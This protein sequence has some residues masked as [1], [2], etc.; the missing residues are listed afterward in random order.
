MSI[1]YPEK[2]SFYRKGMGE[3][4]V[5]LK[6]PEA[7]ESGKIVSGKEGCIFF[8]MAP[9]IKNDPD[10]RIDWKAKAIM[11]IGVNDVGQILAFLNGKAETVK[12]FHK[13]AS[14]SSTCEMAPGQ[15]GSLGVKLSK[16]VGEVNNFASTYLSP[17]DVQILRSVLTAGLP[18]MLGWN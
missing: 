18:T 17:S 12:L 5:N 6:R 7:D 10:G 2:I 16:K 8:E 15:N 1:K 3:L 14:G 4:Q 9:A 13:T 11:K